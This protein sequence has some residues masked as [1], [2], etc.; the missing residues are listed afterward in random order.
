M[1]DA[2]ANA[3]GSTPRLDLEPILLCDTMS[4]PDGDLYSN[5]HPNACW[6]LA[7]L[8][9]PSASFV[10]Y[11]TQYLRSGKRFLGFVGFRACRFLLK[12]RRNN[13]TRRVR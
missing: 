5:P 10:D 12:Q 11:S 8:R 6:S 13:V 1:R 3:G 7:T 4:V 2:Q 9:R